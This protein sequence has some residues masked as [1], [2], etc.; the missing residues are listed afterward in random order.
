M[1][2]ELSQ[3]VKVD[4]ETSFEVAY[5]M[6]LHDVRETYKEQPG[7]AFLIKEVEETLS[8]ENE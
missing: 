1:V 7:Y 3:M 4:V 2:L 8:K 6:A 5:K